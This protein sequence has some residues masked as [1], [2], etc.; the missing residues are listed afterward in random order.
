MRYTNHTINQSVLVKRDSIHYKKNSKIPYTGFFISYQTDGYTKLPYIKDGKK[1][2]VEEGYFKNGVK[3]GE[4]TL[5]WTNGQKM[6]VEY[7]TDGIE[8]G[9]SIS[10][11]ENVQKMWEGLVLNDKKTGLWKYW[12]EIGNLECEGEYL[13]DKKCGKW[14]YYNED[15]S[16]KRVEEY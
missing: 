6:G 3:H 5:W 10:W 12:N 11:Y 2:K 8:N 1:T 7:Y 13:N 4:Y 16:V 15:G 14:T 9:N